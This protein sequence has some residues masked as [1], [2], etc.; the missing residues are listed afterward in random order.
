MSGGCKESGWTGLLPAR[1]CTFGYTTQS[2]QHGRHVLI[3]SRA[4]DAANYFLIGLSRAHGA[5][6]S[7]SVR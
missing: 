2:N 1:G 4:T 5:T 7:A 6:S 3:G